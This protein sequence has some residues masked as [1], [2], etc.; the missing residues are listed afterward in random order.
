MT[1]ILSKQ[2]KVVDVY[3]VKTREGELERNFM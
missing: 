2:G 3:N 1:K